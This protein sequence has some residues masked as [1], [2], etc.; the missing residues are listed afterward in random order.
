MKIT[1]LR[2]TEMPSCFCPVCFKL[3]DAVTA[4]DDTSPDPGNYTVCFGCASVLRFSEN[5]VLMPSSLLEIPEH[6]RLQFAQ[7]V[8]TVKLMI[9]RDA[10]PKENKPLT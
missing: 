1:K 9:E 2:T 6:S 7:L 10:Q 5:M 8:Q 3:L 4:F